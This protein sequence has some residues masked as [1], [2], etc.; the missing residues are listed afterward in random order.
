MVFDDRRHL[1]IIPI[2]VG[3]ACV[4]GYVSGTFRGCQSWQAS[5]LEQVAVSNESF[6]S[7]AGLNVNYGLSQ[8]RNGIPSGASN[9]ILEVYRIRF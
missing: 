4:V 2:F 6:I 1:F 5:G 9:S 3:V 7:P 8:Q